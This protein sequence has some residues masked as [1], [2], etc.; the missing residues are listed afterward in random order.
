MR[1][2]GEGHQLSLCPHGP[3][4][5]EKLA[6]F[7]TMAPD[8]CGQ[9]LT[10]PLLLTLMG[11]NVMLLNADKIT[12]ALAPLICSHFTAYSSRYPLTIYGQK[13]PVLWVLK[14]VWKKKPS[15]IK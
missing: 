7:T 4:L 12:T 15:F 1:L 9:A 14:D 8:G 6:H 10:A 5:V 11:Y 3:V 2:L 13:P